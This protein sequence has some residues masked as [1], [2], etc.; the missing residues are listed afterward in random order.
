MKVPA[1]KTSNSNNVKTTK[2]T[3]PPASKPIPVPKPIKSKEIVNSIP[4]LKHEA[5]VKLLKKQLALAKSKSQGS[6]STPSTKALGQ[7]RK[8]MSKLSNKSKN[9]SVE[10]KML[11]N[12]DYFRTIADPFNF[13]GV[14]IPDLT[15]YPSVPF[16][17]TD[18]RQL[19]L[20]TNGNGYII[21]GNSGKTGQIPQGGLIP[22]TRA[23]G[24]ANNFVVGM[25]S[26]SDASTPINPAVDLFPS[27][28]SPASN[29][30]IYL[31]QW[32]TG[33]VG[34]PEL[35]DKARLVSGGVAVDYTG[36]DFDNAG[37]YTAVMAPRDS[38]IKNFMNNST[39]VPISV[40]QN[41][42]DSKVIPVNKNAGCTVLY[43]PQDFVS[44]NYCDLQTVY[45]DANYALI[46]Q[47]VYG[48][49]FYV[50]VTGGTAGKV[51]Q[52]TCV[53][54]YEAIPLFNTVDLF[55]V[56]TSESDPLELSATFNAL[57]NVVPVAMGTDESL[58]PSHPIN[59]MPNEHSSVEHNVEPIS[60]PG[61]G[62]SFMDSIFEALGGAGG[63]VKE[64]V[65]FAKDVTPLVSTALSML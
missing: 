16:S 18:R 45:D 27:G 26:N 41:L 29:S 62:L 31:Q 65:K 44:L 35:F 46:P 3:T 2:S 58:S 37:T 49:E 51:F 5:Q 47:E 63:P 54:N 60:L 19:T 11:S 14:Q 12:S 39:A 28:D 22:T 53:L 34:I 6:I 9:V 23:S 48:A 32:T 55:S 57:E 59:S 38:V 21:Y 15:L 36:T 4:L 10:Q 7:E 30:P 25:I 13:R 50:V 17:I 64:V 43:R 1:P 33:G 56:S 52:V 40:L 61:E 20:D 42:P 8:L 24:G